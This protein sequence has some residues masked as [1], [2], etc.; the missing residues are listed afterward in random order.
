MAAD[1]LRMANTTVEFPPNC[2]NIIQAGLGFPNTN[3]QYVQHEGQ[4]HGNSNNTP[5]QSPYVRA[6]GKCIKIETKTLGAIQIINGLVHFGFGAIQAVLS[7]RH[8]VTM[9]ILKG[10]P[11]WSGLFYIASGSLSVSTENHLNTNLVNWSV[12]M[13]ITSAAMAS[14]GILA[15]ILELALYP[16]LTHS[17]GE[18]SSKALESVGTGL[19]ILLL[20][21][22][23][24]E[25]CITVL[26]AHFGTQ[27]LADVPHN[28]TEHNINPTGGNPAHPIY[29][30]ISPHTEV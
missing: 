22:S 16:S 10:Y 6:L 24:L 2:A 28:A 1:P 17:F 19:S 3:A 4:Q 11:F 18:T 9:F 14:V 20:L 26:I 29:G 23:S 7:Y 21:F 8:Y 13:N 27:A 5:E 25:F 30:N 15:Y 12:G